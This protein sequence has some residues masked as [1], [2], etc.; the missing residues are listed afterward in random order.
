MAVSSV[1]EMATIAP[2]TAA[3]PASV[4]APDVVPE[5]APD[6]TTTAASRTAQICKSK[7]ISTTADKLGMRPADVKKVIDLLFKQIVDEVAA[8]KKVAIDE[9][10]SWNAQ[11]RKERNGVNPKTQAKIVIPAKRV[12]TFTPSKF[13]KS[14]VASKP[15][16]DEGSVSSEVP[17]G[18]DDGAAAAP[19]AVPAKA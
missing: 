4:A 9:F 13:F 5:D 17:S 3:V 18:S 19:P 2:T 15:D 14:T 8:G 10:G 16:A 7:I 6:K 1:S 12:A 11:E